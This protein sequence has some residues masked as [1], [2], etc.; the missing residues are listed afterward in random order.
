[1]TDSRPE[2]APAAINLDQPSSARIWDCFPG[3]SHNFPGDTVKMLQMWNTNSPEPMHWRTQEEIEALVDGSAL[4]E[5]GVVQA[6]QQW[7]PDAED[8]ERAEQDHDRY[9]S[10]AAVGVKPGSTTG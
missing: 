1:M 10:Y 4:L 6:Q 5:P 9:A 7:R 2:W 8:Q 3:G